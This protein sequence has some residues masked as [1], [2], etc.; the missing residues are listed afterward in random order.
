L[1]YLTE[2]DDIARLAAALG[3]ALRRG[4]VFLFD[5][6]DQ[7]YLSGEWLTREQQ[8][9]AAMDVT[10]RVD[11]LEPGKVYRFRYDCPSGTEAHIGRAYTDDELQAAFEM[12]GAFTLA[13]LHHLSHG[14]HTPH[15][16]YFMAKRS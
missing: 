9:W 4:G 14:W 8:R 3:K 12:S 1:C 11:W 16:R 15:L 10:I 5:M 7:D 6:I 13:P 2:L